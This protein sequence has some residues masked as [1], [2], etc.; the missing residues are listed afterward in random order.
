MS[1]LTTSLMSFFSW[2]RKLESN[3]SHLYPLSEMVVKIFPLYSLSQH[4]VLFFFLFN[5]TQTFKEFVSCLFLNFRRSKLLHAKQKVLFLFFLGNEPW[6]VLTSFCNASLT[7]MLWIWRHLF[8][9]VIP[10]FITASC[11]QLR[12]I[13]HFSCLLSYPVAAPHPPE[14]KKKIK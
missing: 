12:H 5:T 6:F 2:L 3:I 1:P 10:I 13:I 8:F 7:F 14:K 4:S 11:N 9:P